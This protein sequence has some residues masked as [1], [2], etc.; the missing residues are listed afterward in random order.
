MNKL[1]KIVLFILFTFVFIALFGLGAYGIIDDFPDLET[2]PTLFNSFLILLGFIFYTTLLKL[3]LKYSRSQILNI[4]AY[5]LGTIFAV[6]FLLGYF[7]FH[8]IYA[9]ILYSIWVC[10]ALVGI[11]AVLLVVAYFLATKEN[12]GLGTLFLMFG[13][14]LC[15]IGIVSL[16]AGRFLI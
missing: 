11:S 5:L 6:A 10:V 7:L 3:I 16:V 9:L 12:F 15:F 14:V 13:V 2:I 1:L 4:Y 8:E